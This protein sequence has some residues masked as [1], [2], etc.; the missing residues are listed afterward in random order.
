MAGV[1]KLVDESLNILIPRHSQGVERC[2]TMVI[3]ASNTI[4]GMDAR[5]TNIREVM[6]L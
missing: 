4:D 2:V 6:K 3:E 5:Y 1:G